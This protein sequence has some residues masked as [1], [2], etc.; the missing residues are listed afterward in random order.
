[1]QQLRATLACVAA[2]AAALAAAAPAARAAIA[3]TP[4]PHTNDFACAKLQV[5]LDP[6]GAAPGTVTLALRR[7]RAPIGEA[8][9]AIVALAGGPGQSAIPFA[10]DFAEQLGAI[11]VTRDLVVFDQ[12]G[13]GESGALSCKAFRRVHA[14]T[15]PPATMQACAA[16]LGTARR[17]YGTAASV[18][19]IE[20]VRRAAGYEKLVLY[21]TSY[22][23]KVAEDYAQAYPQHVEALVLDSVVP[24]GAPDALNRS[25]FQAVPRVLRE[26]CR[27]D[28]CRRVTRN[29]DRD[30]AA[31]LSRIHGGGLHGR[32]LTP[33]GTSRRFAITAQ[34]LLNA[35][36]VGDFSG[37]LRA[38]LVSSLR[39]A[40]LGDDAPLAR[41]L[42]TVPSEEE[43][44]GEAEGI[45]IPLYYATSCVDQGFPWNPAAGPRRRLAEA[46]A[47][48]RALGASAFA[49]FD[50]SDA[51]RLSDIPACAWWPPGPSEAEPSGP[52]PAVPTLILSGAYDMR[53]PTANA[54]EVAA[55]IPG[56]HL[57]VVPRVGHSVLGAEGGAC[58]DKALQA[59]FASRPVLGCREGPVPARLRPA[60]PAPLR[61]AAIAPLHG[62]R[63]LTGRTARAVQMTLE[64]LA[65]Q[66]AL[67]I[68]TSGDAEALLLSPVLRLGGLRSGWVKLSGGGVSFHDY[69]FV[70]GMTVQ[71][72]LRLESASLRVGGAGAAPG[73]LR[74]GRHHMLVGTLG[75]RHV[76]LAAS[77]ERATA[78]VGSDAVARDAHDPGGTAAG[79]RVLGLA[80]ER[81]RGA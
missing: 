1:M 18:A 70:P 44:G 38:A 30:L 53:T 75:G 22:G 28:A 48:T 24:P 79:L 12:R 55:E 81:R 32:V 80:I 37:P 60:P 59:L 47:A 42:R 40:A 4:C 69:S 77:G 71:G 45:D 49:P 62:Y 76:R 13:T 66:I 78:I 50:S 61:V 10:E 6:S 23:T 63:G 54:R 36:L 56:S 67:T 16:Q 33:G 20:A 58:A 14:A 21:G 35:L 17:Y 26:V 46:L 27:R 15:P 73:T 29:P 2:S 7:H 9:T 34:A 11:A 68:E 74:L 39:S 31:V 52:L 5:P 8:H 51:L 25:S 43:E 57:L 3:Y 72:D 19:D 65:R 41:L 64:D